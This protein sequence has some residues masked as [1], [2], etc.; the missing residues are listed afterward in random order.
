MTKRTDKRGRR[1]GSRSK[2]QFLPNRPGLV[3]KGQGGVFVP[4]LSEA[5]DRLR[6]E[7]TAKTVIE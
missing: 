4:L 5:G 2:G 1:K 7:N 3:H 6:G